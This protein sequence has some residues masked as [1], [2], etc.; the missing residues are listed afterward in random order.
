[1]CETAGC[2]LAPP[3]RL[4][5]LERMESSSRVVEAFKQTGSEVGNSVCCSRCCFDCLLRATFR[6]KCFAAGPMNLI[7]IPRETL[8]IRDLWQTGTLCF[9]TTPYWAACLQT[10]TTSSSHPSRPVLCRSRSGKSPRCVPAV[11]RR[12]APQQ[13]FSSSV[14]IDSW[15]SST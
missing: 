15:S 10:S 8:F 3:F 4:S 14:V 13:R 5:G 2:F 6:A 7:D 12:S 11:T 9:S 1:M